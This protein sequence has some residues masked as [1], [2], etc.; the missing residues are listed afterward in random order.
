M[1]NSFPPFDGQAGYIRWVIFE[2]LSISL[3]PTA[4]GL[5]VGVVSLWFYRY[6]LGRLDTIN[7]EMENATLDLR[8]QLSRF[9]GRVTAGCAID[10]R[11]FGEQPPDEVTRG[12]KFQRRCLFLAGTAL[13]VAWLVQVL[14]SGEL[15]PWVH[16]PL[17]FVVSCLAAYP[18][19]VK[20]LRRRPGGLVALAAIF[21]LCWSVA[22]LV[23]GTRLP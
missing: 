22:E 18:V 15:V 23:L 21:C 13:L 5:L 14:S 8:N 10:G 12:E 6:L 11:M 19:W 2:N 17:K 16:L 20:L 9:P 1:A 4:F 3:W 7:L